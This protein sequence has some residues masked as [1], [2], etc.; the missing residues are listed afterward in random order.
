MFLSEKI[1]KNVLFNSWEFLKFLL[2]LKT[3]SKSEN[4]MFTCE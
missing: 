3:E 2:R 4:K 1:D